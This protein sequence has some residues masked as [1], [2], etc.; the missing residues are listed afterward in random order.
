[1][2]PNLCHSHVSALERC[3]QAPH[4]PALSDAGVSGHLTPCTVEEPLVG[5]VSLD[6]NA[7]AL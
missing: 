4:L 6:L 7:F 5:Q 2:L 3:T 1:M